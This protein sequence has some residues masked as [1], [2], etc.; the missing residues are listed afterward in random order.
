[1]N[2]ALVCAIVCST[3]LAIGAASPPDKDE[4]TLRRKAHKLL[5]DGNYKDSLELFQKLALDGRSN[6][7]TVGND[8]LMAASCLQALNRDNE[9][10]ELRDKFA[11]IHSNNWSAL[12]AAGQS[13]FNAQ[14][15]GTI[16]AGKFERGPHRGGGRY[17][18]SFERDRCRA[19]QLLDQA[20]ALG[21]T[22]AATPATPGTDPNTRSA[23]AGLQLEYARMLMG[24][25]GY[26]DSWRLQYLTDLSKLPDYE[27]GYWRGEYG[28]SAPSGAPVDADGNPVF[29]K[30]PKN[31]AAAQTDG[32]RWRWMLTRA[33]ELD[34]NLSHTVLTQY[35]DFLQQQFDVQTMAFYG[36]YFRSQDSDDNKNE[37]GGMYQLHTLGEDE[38]IARL[39]T[40]IKRFKLPEDA[41]F[42]AIYR[43]LSAHDR[44]GEIFE[45]R[46]QYDKAVDCW[47]KAGQNDRVEQILGNW[48][49][50]EPV[51]T[52][53]AGREASVEFRFRNGTKVSFT[54]QEINIRKLLDDVKEYL[55][56]NPKDLNWER[57]DVQNI[58]YRL[59]EGN[60]VKYVEKKVAEWDL[61]L[62]PRPM[63]F[64]RR[65][66]VQ[67]PLKKAGAYLLTARMADGNISK[68]V[69]WL[70]DTVLVK[71]QLDKQAHFF[72]ADAVTGG[73]LSKINVE[74]FGYRQD[75]TRLEQVV[76][77]QYNVVTT[78]FAEFSDQDGQVLPAAKDFTQNF[79]W[80]IIA[81]TPQEQG[82][83]LAY[84]GFTGIWYGNYR[85]YEYN[86]TKVF[87]ITD[88]PVYRPGQ[89]VR[90]KFWVRHAKYDQPDTSDFAGQSFAMRITDPKGQKI[91]EKNFT[92]DKYGGFDGEF[93]LPADTTLGVY[94][95]SLPGHGHG[96]S[97]RVE[98]YKKP[99]FEVTVEA[100]A[101]PV[102]LGEKIS[103]T[104]TAKYYFGAPVTK[105]KVKYKILR[106]DYAANWY[107]VGIWDWFYGPG[108]WWF[109]YD[110]PWYPGWK[111]WG[112][113]RPYLWWW[114]VSRTPPEIV[115]AAEVPVTPDG[116]LKIEIDTTI[117]KELHGDSDHRYEITVEVTDESRRTITG[118]GVVLVARKPFKVYAW[119]DR[120]HYR[121]GDV[122]Q[123]DFSAQTL[124]NK[125][126]KGKGD[127][128]LYALG[129]KDGAPIE[130]AVEEISLD[131]DA[132]GHAHAQIRAARAGQYRLSYKVTDSAK[133][134]I[135][136]GYLFCVMG[137]AA[138]GS[139]A[140]DFRFNE[141]ELVPDKRE[142]KPGE[143]VR[144]MINTARN[145]GTVV[146]FVR[147]ANGIYLPPKVLRLKGKSAVEE[148]EVTSKDMPNFF[149]EAFTISSGK[150]Y[151]EMREIV[152]PPEQRVL[153]IEV[154]PS[155]KTCKPGESV[156]VK[157]RLSE[158]NGKPYAG[159][160]VMSVYDKAVEYISGGSNIQ[161]I[162]AFFWKWRRHHN[163][164]A[165]CSLNRYFQNI[166]L[167]NARQMNALGI[168]GLLVADEDQAKDDVAVQTIMSVNGAPGG[169]MRRGSR[170]E[171]DMMALS[172][173]PPAPAAAMEASLGVAADAA[174]MAKS[175]LR[176]EASADGNA[177]GGAPAQAVVQPTIRTEFADT[178]YWNASLTT[179]SNG[180]AEVQFKMP[181]NLTG[182]KIRTWAMG[183][184]TKVGEATAEVVTAKK[185]MLRLQAPRFFVE[186]DE[187]VLS[188]NIHNYLDKAKKVRAVLELDG[189]CL[190]L[191]GDKPGTTA[192]VAEVSIEIPAGGE[193]RVDW[194]VKAAREGTAV[195]RMKA[196]T[197]EESDAMQMKFP[198]YV[199]GMLKTESYSGV[200]RLNANK[201]AITINVP[202]ERR[203]D[204][205]R[206]EIRFSPTLAGA[207]VDAL[208]YLA[209]YPYGCTEQTLNKFLPSAITQ[210]VLKDMGID[211]KAI[212]EKRTNLNAQEIGDDKERA[213]Q[214]QR[215]EHN[216]VFDEAEL[217]DMVKQ[218]V[219]RLTAMQLSD[220]GWGWFSGWG[221]QSWPHTTAY[222]V[223][224]LQI[225]KQNGVALVPGVL[226][227]GV[228]WL[229]AYQTQELVKIRNGRKK[230]P[231][232]PWKPNA[233][234]L[235]AFVYMVLVDA[236]Q[237]NKDMREFLYADRNTLPVYAKSMFGMALHKVEDMEKRD[238][239][240]RNIEQF[241][242]E[243]KENQTAYL[244][245]GN[246]GYWW[247]WYGSEYEAHAY[248]LKLLSL[249]APKSERAAGLV[250][251]LLNNRKNATYW[252][253]TRDTAL[254]VEAM[255]DYLRA[256]G[257]DKPDMT[258]EIRVDGRKRK[259]VKI[260]A[261][262]L[263]MFDN[264]FVLFGDAVETGKHTIEIVRS[265]KGP[266]YFNAYL[267]N[268][269]LEEYI[270]RAGLEV[271]VDRKYYKLIKVDKTVK[272]AGARGQALDQK[273]EKYER[274][275]LKM[276]DTL[277]SGDLVE[278]E[279][280]IESKND[281]EYLVFEDMKAAGF[282]PVEVRSG[283]NGN[284][285]GA[286][287]ELRDE[288]VCLFVRSLARGKHS[289]AYRMRAEIPGK[290]SALPTKAHAMYA[291]ELKANSDEIK[292]K[293]ED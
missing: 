211:L 173:V 260:S 105:G 212:R 9:S 102:M 266:V 88:R 248:Y 30:V 17:V 32:E 154:T 288:R 82:G 101:E 111:D 62:K 160:T 220:G 67:T 291:P 189:A 150:L 135:E 215:W 8:L 48:G 285:L 145:G 179:D 293:I 192:T 51:M 281:Y 251:Y 287:M 253:S 168:F 86:Q 193:Q 242:V 197:D 142:Y 191:P 108:Y 166:V 229:Q 79:Q 222:V 196:L 201:A 20:R 144:L 161:E 124:D 140:K 208:P 134:T 69:M 123:A 141:I 167:P 103:A 228:A 218:G 162:K 246:D 177:G 143:K 1:M 93:P 276:L 14:H 155:S 7:A 214:W 209:D 237:D 23:L 120:G 286:Y 127:L 207:M 264:K 257:E 147:P 153:N 19:L 35:A 45:N 115:S 78:G 171:G 156:K 72:V 224:G 182:W 118:Q 27:E 129:Y 178:A 183:H 100:P 6:P 94:Q 274:Q 195:V 158:L 125:P 290:F 165:E 273:V 137:A 33:G 92:A 210:K 221:E 188:A 49:Q 16:I 112:C 259:E 81:T 47:K 42:V 244:N 256:S 128:V 138:D 117:A 190:E 181:E 75:H 270:T 263:F 282:E 25:R 206:L 243:D 5:N 65:I 172:A 15:Y 277:K 283:Y 250:K 18:N 64:D 116:K 41:N 96:T 279:L 275:E 109:A 280:T 217:G 80:L 292:L 269:T 131:T 73:P 278:I 110:Y 231:P 241:L 74:F 136:G 38:T 99:E 289:V 22:V 53:P 186:K 85:D 203:I 13:F 122:V 12:Y 95:L 268:F 106:S 24:Y 107:P 54:A 56:S 52:H 175:A 46:R 247:Y 200:V 119:V 39:A 227:R 10:D 29:H 146:L 236:Q 230:E 185:L 89:P 232:F 159:S 157:V 262:N 240:I 234:A 238:M 233:D 152:V 40:G 202:K 3:A 26:Q 60:Q 97:F 71:K 70:D 258:V 180:M 265:G 133:H 245:L 254:C 255:A 28:Y 121:V 261:E 170:G 176:A 83:R 44:L 267:S 37:A 174:P 272:T 61:E 252:K 235:D 98:E 130:T 126:V 114:P 194:R 226:E 187:V 104:A 91:L 43:K 63:H 66:T 87:A 149:V 34:A 204:E 205:S 199:H 113:C 11:G 271:K 2:R 132:E 68:I 36:V 164:S 148:I 184:G 57:M 163:S 50:F 249:V 90:F 284:D 219:K 213:A 216:A 169:A 225:A 84:L 239:V 151:S 76:G 21:E 139:G 58:G 4:E 59:V 55:K 77:R 31:W 223:H 198:V